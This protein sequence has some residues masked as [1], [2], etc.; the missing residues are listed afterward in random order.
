MIVGN[1]NIIAENNLIQCQAYT[2]LNGF[3]AQEL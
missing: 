3:N 1:L 2:I